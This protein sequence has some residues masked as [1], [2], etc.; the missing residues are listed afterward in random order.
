MQPLRSTRGESAAG[1][2]LTMAMRAAKT[3]KRLNCMVVM[4]CFDSQVV[5]WLMS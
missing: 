4:F 1:E 2:A 3:R 5:G